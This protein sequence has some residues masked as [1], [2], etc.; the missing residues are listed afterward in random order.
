MKATVNR[1]ELVDI[2]SKVRRVVPRRN[3]LD[4]LTMVM[5]TAGKGQLEIIGGDTEKY[6]IGSCK[7]KVNKAG[8]VCVN[9]ERLEPFLKAVSEDDVTIITK[10]EVETHTRSDYKEDPE[11]G[12]WVPVDVPYDVVSVSFRAECGEAATDAPAESAEKYP[13]VKLFKGQN[14]KVSG[15]NKALTEIGYAMAS[16]ETRPTLYGVCFRGNNL[17]ACD[18]YRLAITKVKM[19][20]KIDD[21]LIIPKNVAEIIGKIMTDI[22]IRYREADGQRHIIVEGA[23]VQMF[24]VTRCTKY[25]DYEK[26]IPKGGIAFKVD[27]DELRKALVLVGRSQP[28]AN[29]VVLRTRGKKV[30]VTAKAMNGDGCTETKIPSQGRVEIGFNIKYLNDLLARMGGSMVMRTQKQKDGPALVKD[31][32]TTHVLVP[33]Q[34][35]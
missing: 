2:L 34:T 30:S 10:E 25:P 26:L 6:L 18:G 9:L 13:A 21:D 1:R 20:R 17:V 23:G 7:A 33:M 16:E 14:I 32:T 5:L 15:F 11:T 31:K 24:I 35:E 4:V 3:S 29:K 19:S 28:E 22:A 8:S 12:R 27:A